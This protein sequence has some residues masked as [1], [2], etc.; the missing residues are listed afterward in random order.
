MGK[1]EEGRTQAEFT[2][3]TGGALITKSL[4]YVAEDL[5]CFWLLHLYA[6]HL[7]Y[8]L[9]D[10]QPFTYMKLS[11]KQT[12]AVARIEDGNGGILSSEKIEYADFPLS[13]FT[14]FGCWNGDYWVIMLPE[15]Y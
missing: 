10:E 5:G 13:D 3:V 4:Y 9:P 7:S 2:R 6:S 8:L 15:D 11:V 14:L 1:K 12:S